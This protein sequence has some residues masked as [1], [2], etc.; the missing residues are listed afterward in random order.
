MIAPPATPGCERVRQVGGLALAVGILVDDATVTIE[1]IERHLHRDHSQ[2]LSVAR[3]PISVCPL[4]EAVVFA[5][6]ASYVLSRTLVPTLMLT[7]QLVSDY[8]TLREL[9]AEIDV[10]NRSLI[11]ERDALTFITSSRRN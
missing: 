9:D 2:V 5:M 4:A 7:A 3:R 6:L 8:F 10:V 1:N 11:L